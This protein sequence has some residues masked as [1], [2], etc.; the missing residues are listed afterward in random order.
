MSTKEE[1]DSLTL[2][3]L[4][5][6]NKLSEAQVNQQIGDQDLIELADQFDGHIE[7]YIEHEQFGLEPHEQAHV[8]NQKKVSEAARIF[9]S[10]WK[11]KR[12][13]KATFI[14]LLEILIEINKETVAQCVCKYV[15]TRQ[16]SEEYSPTS[17]RVPTRQYNPT[18]LSRV[19][20]AL[21]A[22]GLLLLVLCLFAISI[23]VTQKPQ[24]ITLQSRGPDLIMTNFE[25]HKRGGDMWYSPPVYT[26]HEGYKICLGVSANG[27]RSGKG[28]HIKVAVYFM[29]GEFDDSLEWPF[30]GIIH[31]S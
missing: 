15:K 8:K 21:E 31:F 1:T 24:T 18:K 22:V 7:D 9:L 6:E 23:F 5:K 12:A 13:Q 14:A 4:L 16:L 27:E 3:S 20:L 11:Q 26:H 25:Q 2:E 30:R 29:R 17:V 19:L 10:Y 28:N